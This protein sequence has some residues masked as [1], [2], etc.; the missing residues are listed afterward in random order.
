MKKFLLICAALLI[1]VF[2]CGQIAFAQWDNRG[3]SQYGVSAAA[4]ETIE[5]SLWTFRSNVWDGYI[6]FQE[7]GKYLTHWGWGT[8]S[9][10]PDGKGLH[11]A[12]D[13]NDRT[14]EVAFTDNGFRF[15]GIGNNGLLINGILLCSKYQ[16]PGP[17]V[18]DEVREEI[19]TMY[20]N[21]L[22]RDAES[23]EFIG[24]L[25]RYVQGVSVETMRE[26]LLQSPEYLKKAAEAAQK[27]KEMEESGQ[28]GW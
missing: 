2:S 7:G 20:K 24:E 6:D 28:L 21:I 12:N 17:Q 5:Y 25:R 1:C 19:K 26:E 23:K 15:Q 11:L 8:W 10:T 3:C 14:Y 13:Y 22:G 16:G 4:P 9:V 27:I 18:P